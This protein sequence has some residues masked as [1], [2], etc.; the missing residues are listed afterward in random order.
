VGVLTVTWGGAYQAFILDADRRVPVMHAPSLSAY[1]PMTA[2]MRRLYSADG[3]RVDYSRP[4]FA[5]R[6]PVG[7][8][9]LFAR[10]CRKCVD[11]IGLPD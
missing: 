4:L 3:S 7:H 9:L 6:L 11:R 1:R 8:A 2:C 5:A 10:P